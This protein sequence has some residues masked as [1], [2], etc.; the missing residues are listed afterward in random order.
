MTGFCKEEEADV[1]FADKAKWLLEDELKKLPAQYSRGPAW[2]PCT[3][4]DRNLFTGQ[5]PASSGPLA[6]ELVEAL[7]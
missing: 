1:G 3:V 5:N 7:T 4:V 2:E 6:K